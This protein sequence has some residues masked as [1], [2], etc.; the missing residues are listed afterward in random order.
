MTFARIAVVMSNRPTIHLPG[1]FL[2]PALLAPAAFAQDRATPP[3]DKPAPVPTTAVPTTQRN[4]AHAY[5]LIE[6]EKGNIQIELYP[7]EAPKTV[8]NFV[9]LAKKGYYNGLKFHR[10]VPNFVIQGGDPKGDG[11]GGPGY[12]IPDERNK[13][14]THTVGAVAMAKTPA[15]NSAGSQFYIVIGQ[16]APALDG[17]YTVFGKVIAGQDV[18]ERIAVGDQM[19]R[20]S[21]EEPA[22]GLP[23]VAG[24]QIPPKPGPPVMMRIARAVSRVEPTEPAAAKG[25]QYQKNVIVRV[26]IDPTGRHETT[27]IQGSGNPDV[28]QAVQK[29]LA[30]WKWEPGLDKDNKPVQS[31]QIFTVEV[32]SPEA[33]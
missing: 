31:Y 21:V 15:P 25:K 28:D 30:G 27:L 18:A 19:T 29:A 8:S 10:V 9:T 13:K 33:K 6:T 20:V 1:I 26:G 3:A 4:P 22:G 24:V 2:V 32:R 12:T 17:G 16:P 23:P 7:E 11:S 14:L 5:A